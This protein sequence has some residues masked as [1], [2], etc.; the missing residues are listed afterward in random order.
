MAEV[1]D[2][3]IASANSAVEIAIGLIGAMALWL[4]LM[5]VLRDAGFMAALARAL[6]PAMRRLFPEVP[7]DHPAMGAMI[8]NIS[9]NMLGLGNAATPFGLKAMQELEKLNPRPGVATN[10]MALFLAINT[11]GVAVMPLGVIAVRASLGSADPAGIF[12]PSILATASSTVIAILVAKLLEGR[13]AFALERY[14]ERT[15][16]AGA[17]LADGIKGLAEAE[18]TAAIDARLAPARMVWLPVFVV[19]VIVAI[20]M[21]AR[22]GEAA[23][24]AWDLSRAI[25]SSWLLPVLMVVILLAGFGRRVNVYDSVIIGAREAFQIFV[26]IIPFLVAILVAVGMFRASGALDFL[27]AGLATF[28]TIPSEGVLMGLV[29]PLSGS[30]AFGVMTEAMQ[31]NGPDSFTGYLVS[32]LNG[33]TETT[34][35]VLALYLGSVAVRTGRH[36]VI[37]CLAAD[38][39]GFFAAYFWCRV[40]FA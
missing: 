5:R 34:F 13:T 9:D 37:A 4:G 23:V 16:P 21:E 31:A 38:V 35:Y 14:P 15:E 1:M 32:V 18:Q 39:T 11:S 7:A 40:F 26:M 27:A 30:G 10:S 36:A 24:G 19:L 25:L 6:S 29:R 17:S 20:G 28:T 12:V 8:M 22:S 3:S 33:S 2:A